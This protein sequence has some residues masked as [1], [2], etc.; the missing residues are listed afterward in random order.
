MCMDFKNLASPA[1][2]VW[3]MRLWAAFNIVFGIIMGSLHQRGVLVTLNYL[4]EVQYEGVQVWWK[5]YKPPAYLLANTDLIISEKED[6]KSAKQN[7]LVDLM[8]ADVNELAGVLSHFDNSILITPHSSVPLIERLNATRFVF[9]KIWDYGYHL[10]LDHIDF[11]DLR[12]LQPG[13]DVYN[14]TQLV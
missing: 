12:T 4:R 6:I 7:H 14:V 10:D 11:S 3:T 13:I 9:D 1:V 2:I 5:T 8:G